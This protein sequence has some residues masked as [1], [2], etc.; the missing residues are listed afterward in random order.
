MRTSGIVATG[1][2]V[3]I[4]VGSVCL[5]T[6]TQAKAASTAVW[7]ASRGT[8]PT[9]SPV[10]HRRTWASTAPPGSP[11]AAVKLPFGLAVQLRSQLGITPEQFLADGQAAADAGKVVASLQADG[12]TVFGTRLKGTTLTVT[13]RDAAGA[14]AA[15][16][17]GAEAVIGTAQ[18]VKTVRAKAFSSPADGSSALLGGDLWFYFTNP[19]AGEGLV[20]ST[21]FNGYNKST[22][23]KEFLTAG[24]CADYQHTVNPASQWRG[25]RRHMTRTR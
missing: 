21:G 1:A 16:A 13:V 4:A 25:V 7:S 17:D 15:E 8:H 19:S 24:H 11:K 18:P 14:A 22:G 10:S 23:A 5:S 2:V 3:A 9:V 6:A 20:C 12:V